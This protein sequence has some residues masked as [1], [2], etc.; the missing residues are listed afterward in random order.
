MIWAVAIV[1]VILSILCYQMVFVV[2]KAVLGR[3]G[4]RGE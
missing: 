2:E 3:L 4:M 1:S